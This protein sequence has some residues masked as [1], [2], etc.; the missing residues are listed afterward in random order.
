MNAA[1]G[2]LYELGIAE[3]DFQKV[4]KREMGRSPI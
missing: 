1:G 4:L 2:I 3:F